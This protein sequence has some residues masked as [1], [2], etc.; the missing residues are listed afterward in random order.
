MPRR[1]IATIALALAAL[2]AA[3]ALAP[4]ADA[5][6]KKPTLVITE[7]PA[8]VRLVPGETIAITL[9]TN[10]TTG[11]SWSAQTAGKPGAIT[12]SK[13]VYQAPDNTNGMVGVP[14]KTTWTV[15]AKKNGTGVVK[16]VATP[17]GG[18][19]GTTQTVTVIVKSC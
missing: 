14:G 13:G 2:L 4:A 3:A 9:P 10:R 8:Q 6:G 18:G 19:A 7:T 15:T 1:L 5:A 16:I 17:P 11:Y 12:V